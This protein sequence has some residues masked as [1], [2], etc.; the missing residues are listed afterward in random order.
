MRGGGSCWSHPCTGG[1]LPSSAPIIPGDPNLPGGPP[2]GVVAY[3]VWVPVIQSPARGRPTIVGGL[4][5]PLSRGRIPP[6]SLQTEFPPIPANDLHLPAPLC[7]SP[8]GDGMGG[9][10]AST[11]LPVPSP[12][13]PSGVIRLVCRYLIVYVVVVVVIVVVVLE[14]ST[15]CTSYHQLYPHNQKIGFVSCSACP[16]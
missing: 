5:P 7:T 1:A 10:A 3:G 14:I 16:I 6:L 15:L 2:L 8:H 9:S 4:P 11:P 13:I 12:V